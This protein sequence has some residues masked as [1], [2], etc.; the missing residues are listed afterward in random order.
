VSTVEP[1]GAPSGL[2]AL[3]TWLA[4]VLLIGNALDLCWKFVHWSQYSAGVKLWQIA[5]ALAV[6][7]FFMLLLLL[8]F[9]T[10]RSRAAGES[11]SVK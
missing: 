3:A 6:R 1:T 5:I 9:L 11:A 2:R 8:V 4:L 10:G 7:L